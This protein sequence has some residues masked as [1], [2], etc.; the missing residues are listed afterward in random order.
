MISVL[1]F[2]E[3]G[4]VEAATR[5]VAWLEDR[6]I[7]GARGDA[8]E[9]SD[10]DPI[11][12]FWLGRLGPKDE[13][14]KSDGRGDR[15]EPCAIGIRFRPAVGKSKFSIAISARAWSRK[16]NKEGDRPWLW[17]KLPAIAFEVNVDFPDGADELVLG[18]EEFDARFKAIKG[19][20]LMAEIRVVRRRYGTNFV[21]EATLVN[22]STPKDA[23]CDGRLFECWLEV[24][25]IDSIP[26]EL[27]SL[28]DT[29]RYDRRVA[30]FGINCGV[31][32]S[33]GALSTSDAPAKTRMRPKYWASSSPEPDISFQRLESDPI[34]PAAELTAAFESWAETAWSEKVLEARRIAERWTPAM[35]KEASKAAALFHDELKRVREGVA[36]LEGDPKLRTAFSAMNR[37]MA[38]S[39]SGKYDRWRPFQFAFLLA[40]L[41]SL[42]NTDEESGVADVVWFATGGGKTETY[43]GLLVTAAILDRMGGKTSGV[44][45]WSRFPLRMLSLQQTQRFANAL[46]GAEI[47]RRQMGLAGD[48]F[49]LG[50]LVGGT[51]TPNRVRKDK[52][53]E[54][55]WD[56]DQVEDMVNPFLLIETCPFCRQHSVTTKFRRGDWRLIHEC[57]NRDCFSYGQPLPIFVVDEEIWRFLPTIVVGTLDKAAN[58]GFQPGMRGLVGAP[59]GTCSREGHGFTYAIRSDRP[60]GCLVP[61]CRANRAELPMPEAVFA[62]RFRLQDELHLLRDSLGA[63]DAHYEAVLDS[64]Q[65]HLSGRLPKILA[66]S[67]TLSGYEKQVDVLFRR[68]A[69]VFPQPPPEDGR[70]FWTSESDDLM[71]RYLALAPRGL[72][73]EFAVDRLVITLQGCV[74]RL[75]D[76][77][78]AVCAELSISSDY[79]PFLV[80]NYGTDVVYGNTLRD[81][82]AVMRSSQTQYGAVGSALNTASLTGR[83]DFEEVRATLAR[84]E[85]PEDDFSS[86]VHLV[87]ASSMMSHGV[88]IDRLNVMIMLGL[89]LGVAEF[90]QAT[91]RVGRKWP[92]LVI[93]VPKVARERDASVYRSF[94]EFVSHGDRFVEP[95]PITRKSRRVLERTISGMEIARLLLLH[96]KEAPGPLTT[97]KGL[98]AWLKVNPDGLKADKAAI[99]Q[100]LGLTDRDLFLLDELDAWFGGFARNLREPGTDVRFTS[101]LSPNGPPMMS[102]RD[103]EEQAPVA[104]ES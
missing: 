77:G 30:A 60:N 26:F 13:V 9:V 61:D 20:G 73:V 21:L 86:R 1:P 25:G 56:V 71:R 96:E 79:N 80:S 72:T 82:D 11:G 49:S 93:V 85:K 24:R 7:A 52:G 47:V 100:S 104:G 33:E 67:A 45:A 28:P 68:S 83:T 46:A 64:I 4:K 66:S 99:A 55:D 2:S 15:L 34:A 39:A 3:E 14:T 5:F 17:T 98:N 40:N 23:F 32:P 41:K 35:T 48:P 51:A 97:P 88:D 94:P 103:V 8:E 44:T 18:V 38:I 90:I 27:D 91:A 43:L 74:R 101:D 63:V 92:A 12:K 53:R 50:F 10:V 22:T 87:A 59:W 95:I 58:V 6:A 70:G 16:R 29:F 65:L 78:E 102:L 42:V 19:D 89:P 84:L 54:S 57:S 75:L 81:L 37:A 69:R 76:D 62:P 31:S 36:L